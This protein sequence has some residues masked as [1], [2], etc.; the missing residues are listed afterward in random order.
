MGRREPKPRHSLYSL[1]SLYTC[2]VTL[3]TLMTLMT[4]PITATLN[5]RASARVIQAAVL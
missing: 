5:V 3:V 2:S 4:R 1:H